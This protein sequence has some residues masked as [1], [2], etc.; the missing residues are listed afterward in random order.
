MSSN[1]RVEVLN[2]YKGWL[3]NSFLFTGVGI[4]IGNFIPPP[5]YLMFSIGM[6]ISCL[7][8]SFSKGKT[9]LFMM[10][11]FNTITGVALSLIMAAYQSSSILVAGLITIITISVCV[12]IA[13]KPGANYSGLGKY[14]FVALLGLLIYELL[15]IFLALPAVNGLAIILFAVYTIYDVNLFVRLVEDN[16]YMSDEEIIMHVAN[17]YLDIVNIFIRVLAIV[18]KHD[19]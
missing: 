9:K 6:L 16:I 4:V 5:L 18:G 8:M 17:F 2:L 10:Y 11:L 15:A 1:D 12:S 13:T 19:D 3:L 7:L 14:L